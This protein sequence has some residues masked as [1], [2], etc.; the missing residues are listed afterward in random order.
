MLD[1][2]WRQSEGAA[3][4]DQDVLVACGSAA[5]GDSSF[6]LAVHSWPSLVEEEVLAESLGASSLAHRG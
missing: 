5:E 4:G 2:D 3:G 6:V 1:G